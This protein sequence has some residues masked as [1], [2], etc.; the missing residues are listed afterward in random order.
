MI[1]VFQFLK[2]A[3]KTALGLFRH[4][5]HETLELNEVWEGF[6]LYKSVRLDNRFTVHCPNMSIWLQFTLLLYLEYRQFA[7]YKRALSVKK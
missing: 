7:N 4:V 2:Y 1:L 3:Q 5:K 6:F